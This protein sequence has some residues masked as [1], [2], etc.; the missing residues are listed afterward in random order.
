[1]SLCGLSQG[2]EVGLE[3]RV[4]EHLLLRY[5]ARSCSTQSL[6]NLIHKS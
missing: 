2:L 1:M 5:S 4:V 3:D 6:H